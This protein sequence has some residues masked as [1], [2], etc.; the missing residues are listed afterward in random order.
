LNHP[1]Q[2]TKS[3]VYRFCVRNGIAYHASQIALTTFC[4]FV[5]ELN[6]FT[7]GTIQAKNRR[8]LAFSMQYA[9]AALAAD[10]DVLARHIGGRQ[11]KLNLR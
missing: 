5:R 11:A 8:R 4:R 7:Q 3:A 9:T 1:T 6:E 2:A 10:N